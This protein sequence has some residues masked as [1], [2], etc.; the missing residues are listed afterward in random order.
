MEKKKILESYVDWII[1][2]R[3]IVLLISL[4]ILLTAGAGIKNLGF[5]NNY[6]L[7]FNDDNLQLKALDKINSEFNESRNVYIAIE[8]SD[9]NIFTP[10]NLHA[11]RELE[12][13]AWLIPHSIRVDAIT[14]YQHTYA[15]GDELIIESLVP[16][17][18]NLDSVQIDRIKNIAF[19]EN[20]IKGRLVSADGMMAGI[21]VLLNT[22]PDSTHHDMEVVA[23]A[24]QIADDFEQK[25][26]NL[27]TYITG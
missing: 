7:F 13:D 22:D 1:N 11:I 12:K 5:K 15:H 19:G 9:G 26:P 2:R 25:Y 6:R 23:Y 4:V 20:T 14:N 8:D 18:L 27:Q 17:S 3:W 16:E 21:N 24:R 10:D